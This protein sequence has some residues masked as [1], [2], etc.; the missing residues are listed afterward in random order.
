MEII[1]ITLDCAN[2]KFIEEDTTKSKTTAGAKYKVSF[3]PF[4]IDLKKDLRLFSESN[5]KNT[6]KIAIEKTKGEIPKRRLLETSAIGILKS[7][8][9]PIME[10]VPKILFLYFIKYSLSLISSDGRIHK[11]ERKK[12]QAE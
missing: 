10:I 9:N 11:I 12:N 4:K 7:I 5:Q 8:D 6:P 2:N 1:S 3:A